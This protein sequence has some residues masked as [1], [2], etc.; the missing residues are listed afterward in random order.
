MRQVSF[1]KV[2]TF[3]FNKCC[4]SSADLMKRATTNGLPNVAIE[5]LRR[6]RQ[7]RKAIM[8]K[9][10]SKPNLLKKSES[11]QIQN[12][13]VLFDLKRQRCKSLISR[14]EKRYAGLSIKLIKRKKK[15]ASVSKH[16]V[17]LT[18]IEEE[19]TQ[20]I[21]TENNRKIMVSAFN[22]KIKDMFLTS[23]PLHKPVTKRA[24]ATCRTNKKSA[25]LAGSENSVSVSHQPM[26][27]LKIS[28]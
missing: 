12:K 28:I 16:E 17:P 13:E 25:L 15:A 1:F 26:P 6:R 19:V 20:V 7:Y 9:L 14:N 5:Y 4:F 8:D 27:S 18:K 21:S 11:Y 2:K 24:S 3:D 10:I 23:R 22:Q